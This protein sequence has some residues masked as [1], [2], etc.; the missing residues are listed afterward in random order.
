[1]EKKKR[2]YVDTCVFSALFD[3]DESRRQETTRFWD[4]VRKEGIVVIV[5]DVLAGEIERAPLHV[6]DFFDT[7]PKN[8]ID[9]IAV[10]ETAKALA[11]QYV[12]AGVISKN[13]LAD[14]LHVALATINKADVLVSWNLHDVVKRKD[15]Y[16]NVNDR[17][18]Y[19]QIEIQTPTEAIQ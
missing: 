17:N 6:R 10:S 15:K 3:T 14:C 7:F 13:S 4:A 1:M 19:P 5:S 16:N 9:R 8:H 18:G 2:I 11:E 12:C